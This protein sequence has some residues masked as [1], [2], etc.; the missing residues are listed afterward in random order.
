MKTIATHIV[1]NVIIALAETYLRLLPEA[2]KAVK[3]GNE[4][5]TAAF[6]KS[7][8]QEMHK[9][10]DIVI[11]ELMPEILDK[12]DLVKSLIKYAIQE[13]SKDNNDHIISR[14]TP[15]I[16]SSHLTGQSLIPA[17]TEF[18]ND[19]I[20]RAHF[21]LEHPDLTP[22]ELHEQLAKEAGKPA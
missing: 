13:E 22:D 4:T 8:A 16:L 15:M 21:I 9:A 11:D 14:I 18:L 20:H 6:A 2:E 3:V 7:M 10:V 1:P 12:P 5:L 17:C 19:I